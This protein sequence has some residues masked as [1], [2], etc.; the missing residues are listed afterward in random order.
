MAVSF[1]KQILKGYGPTTLES[2]ES[3]TADSFKSLVST[4]YKIQLRGIVRSVILRD[5]TVFA[6]VER[7]IGGEDDHAHGGYFNCESY[8]H[9]DGMTFPEIFI[10]TDIVP[11]ANDINRYVGKPALVTVQDGFAIHA[12][13]LHIPQLLTTI[14]PSTIRAVR[15]RLQNGPENDIFS[16]IGL[17]VW[18]SFGVLP[19]AVKALKEMVFKSEEHLDKVVTIEGEG[20]WNKDTAQL[21]KGE[22]IVPATDIMLGLNRQGM[23]TNKCHNPTRIFSAK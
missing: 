13:V 8:E 11:I 7:D 10:P 2:I 22:A 3:A 4:D 19:D 23:K 9:V 16:E 21:Q 1:N 5:D 17:K 18:E 15:E 14:K 20:S 6:V 12:S